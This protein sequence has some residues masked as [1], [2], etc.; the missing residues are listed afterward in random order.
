MRWIPLLVILAACSGHDPLPGK[1]TFNRHTGTTV[2]TGPVGT[3]RADDLTMVLLQPTILTKKTG[4]ISFDLT[5][6][7]NRSDNNWPKIHSVWRFGKRLPYKSL[8]TRRNGN[9][10]TEFGEVPMSEA[11]FEDIAAKQFGY[12][13]QI[14]GNPGIWTVTVDPA[15]FAEA[16]KLHRQD[17]VR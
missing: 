1:T 9:D 10:R 6:A 12:E 13:I 7:T 5:I 3:T 8:S 15:A 11:T 17:K 2:T 16:L 4:P 14:H